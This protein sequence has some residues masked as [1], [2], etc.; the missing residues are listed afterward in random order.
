MRVH[1]PVK[2]KL[3]GTSLR[4]LRP[5]PAP[6]ILAELLELRPPLRPVRRGFDTV[7]LRDAKALLKELS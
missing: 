3:G 1:I 6:N 4:N 5:P 7:E 2:I